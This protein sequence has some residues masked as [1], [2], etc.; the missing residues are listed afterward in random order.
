M[1]RLKTLFKSTL[2]KRKT[3][4]IPIPKTTTDIVNRYKQEALLLTEDKKSVYKDFN[5]LIYSIRTNSELD[6]KQKSQ[7]LLL[8]DLIKK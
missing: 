4:F 2:F 5:D 3:L 7:L 8:V 6:I 1:Q